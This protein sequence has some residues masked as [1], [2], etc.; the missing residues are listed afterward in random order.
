V[1][2]TVLGIIGGVVGLALIVLLAVSIAGEE[3]VDA[4]IGYGD[5]VVTG[6]SLPVY[7]AQAGDPTVGLTAP[8]VEGADWNGNEV[9]IGPDGQAKIIIFLAHWCPHCQAEVPVV[10]SWIEAGNLPDDVDLYGVTTSTDRLRPNWPPQDWL[11]EEGW[12]PPTVMDDQIG[13]IAGNFGMAGTPFYAVLDGDNNVIRRVSGEIGV[14]GL[15]ALV[16]EA[17]AANA[18]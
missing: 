11:E 6:E 9:T 10:Q 13:T 2:K 15:N 18:G 8:T 17:Q 3:E 7:N 16:A 1:N 4:S 5:P 12:T 14:A